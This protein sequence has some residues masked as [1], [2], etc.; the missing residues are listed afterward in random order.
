MRR[1]R[2]P[3]YPAVV[4][5][6][7]ITLAASAAFGQS[8]VV[9]G[10]A[11]GRMLGFA[12]ATPT[13]PISTGRPSF[14]TGP[15]TVPKGY[16]QLEGGYRFAHDGAADAQTLPQLSLRAGVA[17]R[18][19]LR[20]GWAGFIG[21]GG[22]G[23]DFDPADLVLG[24]KYTVYAPSGSPLAVGVLGQLSVPTGGGAATSGSYDPSLGLLW[25]Y[26]VAGP[27]G[28]FG[29]V[30]VSSLTDPADDRF[31][32]TGA[33]VGA[34]FPVARSLDGFV[35]YYGLFDS[36]AGA[37]PSHNLDGGLLY[38]VSDNFQLDVNATVGLND[39]ASDYALGA[40][41]GVRF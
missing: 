26:D 20:F 16:L 39:K 3:G 32:R 27:V 38:L 18:V 10:G 5:A 6:L 24:V 8:R 22:D 34:G 23:S 36:G 9:E 15:G 13:G 37:G 40:G 19:E 4:A 2:T 25:S 28:V 17:D 41:F 7:A 33:S 11:L 21:T 30:L 35:E 31:T 14:S 1:H 29:T 12:S